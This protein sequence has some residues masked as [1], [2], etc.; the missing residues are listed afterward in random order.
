M[1]ESQEEQTRAQ[2]SFMRVPITGTIGCAVPVLPGTPEAEA[3]LEFR[4][5]MCAADADW[6]IG[7]VP[8][9]DYHARLVCVRAEI[10]WPGVVAEAERDLE[11]AE[12][13]WSA[14]QKHSQEDARAS[15]AHFAKGADR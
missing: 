10:D 1:S 15:A 11:S 7:L 8:T 12:R 2:I 5:E 4:T 13:P 14:R 9:C 6:I 3:P